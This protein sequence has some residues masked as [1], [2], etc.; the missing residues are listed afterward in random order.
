LASQAD[1]QPLAEGQQGKLE[2]KLRE[3]IHDDMISSGQLILLAYWFS[4]VELFLQIG[5]SSG[6]TALL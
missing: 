4:F 6:S 2:G 5:A 1:I 3:H